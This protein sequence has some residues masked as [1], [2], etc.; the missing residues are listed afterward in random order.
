MWRLAC[1]FQN[2]VIDDSVF[3][4]WDTALPKT[5]PCS[6]CDRLTSILII[7][8]IRAIH[9]PHW[10]H[11]G[12][13]HDSSPRCIL[14]NMSEWYLSVRRHF[15]FSGQQRQTW[16]TRTSLARVADLAFQSAIALIAKVSAQREFLRHTI[17]FVEAFRRYFVFPSDAGQG[18]FL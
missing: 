3:G 17:D 14:S 7:T 8:T 4:T 1:Y 11:E 15:D 6:E 2:S 16:S 5:W 13:V 12:A 10:A 9:R 18:T